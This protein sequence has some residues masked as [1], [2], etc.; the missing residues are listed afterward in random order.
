MSKAGDLAAL[1]ARQP[2]SGGPAQMP[3][4]GVSGHEV[5]RLADLRQA[6][7]PAMNG[8]RL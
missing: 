7:Q 4:R 2:A 1:R 5:D 8:N 3:G 6:P